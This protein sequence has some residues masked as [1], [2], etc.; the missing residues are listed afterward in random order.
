MGN[1]I[2]DKAMLVNLRISQ[3]TARK[4]DRDATATVEA[5]YN[6]AGAGRFNKALIA[7]SALKEVQQ[8]AN[9]LRTY[10][11]TQTLPWT[12]DNYRLLAS[13]NFLPYTERVRELTSVFDL[14]SNYVITNYSALVEDART[15]LNGMFNARDYPTDIRERYG[16]NVDIVPV[17]SGEDFRVALQNGELERIKSDIDTRT[18]ERVEN[19]HRDLYRRLAETVSRIAERLSHPT[20]IFRDT[21]ISN[22]REL[23]ETIPRLSI[24]DDPELEALRRDAENKLCNVDAQDLREDPDLRT[25]TAVNANG[26]L[27]AMEGL[28]GN[29]DS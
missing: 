7:Q 24:I 23:C 25:A 9:A 20:A 5:H 14:A 18:Q 4:Y 11:Y 1:T 21:L 19:A 29:S 27:A 13:A 10:H 15:T 16:V 28:Y 22:L 12:D 17:P 6:T 3:W 2:Q 8:A 26:V